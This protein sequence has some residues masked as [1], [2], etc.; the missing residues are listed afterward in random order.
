MGKGWIV[1]VT[2]GPYVYSSMF[3]NFMPTVSGGT[4]HEW[5]Q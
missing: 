5:V 4:I 2:Y 3:Q 1:I